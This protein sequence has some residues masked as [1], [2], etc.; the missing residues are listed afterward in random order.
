M[1]VEYHFYYIG[2]HTGTWWVCDDYIGTTMLRNEF[3]CK[4]ILHVPGIKVSIAD[5]IY[6]RINFRVFYRLGHVFYAYNFAR[7]TCHEV[8]YR[9]RA[10][11]KVINE[12]SSVAIP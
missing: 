12:R 8:C 10:C 2:V 3:S 5:A 1:C 7:S 9:S 11:V 4:N 6:P